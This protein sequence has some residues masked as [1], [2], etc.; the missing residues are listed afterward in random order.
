MADVQTKFKAALDVIQSLPKDGPYRPAPNMLLMFYAYY[1][2]ATEGPCNKPKPWS[3]DVINKAKWDAWNKLGNMT[4]ETA[5]DNYVKELTKVMQ[6]TPR[7]PDDQIIEVLPASDK[8][9]N[10][11]QTLGNFYEVV[12]VKNQDV[13]K[14]KRLA[15]GN[16]G[17][18]ENDETPIPKVNGNHV[19]SNGHNHVEA[20]DDITA[21]DVIVADDRVQQEVEVRS[22]SDDEFCDT[23]TDVAVVTKNYSLSHSEASSL[24]TESLN[25]TPSKDGNVSAVEQ[26]L[27]FDESQPLMD[28]GERGAR[29]VDRL[30]STHTEGTTSTPSESTYP[31]IHDTPSRLPLQGGAGG[32]D[33]PWR[34]HG[35]KHAE[36][37]ERI[38][39]V[40]LQLQRDMHSVLNR[41]TTLE[42][43][44]MARQQ[45]SQ[46]RHHCCLH[47]SNGKTTQPSW[48]PFSDI[49]PKTAL[50]FIIW[51]FLARIIMMFLRR[52]ARRRR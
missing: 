46:H 45:D 24:S 50:F 44:I 4:Q 43:I 9:A 20:D 23:S 1:K 2:Q 49:H 7:I 37:E 52:Y 25:G 21:D 48:W 18:K 12:D 35:D 38:A 8:S 36:I 51:P 22:E 27:R 42:T 47:Q 19:Q 40:L 6:D 14:L 17:D 39:V 31:Q 34:N 5:M 13:E 30:K 16:A 11:I 26:L 41:L 33:E 32:S 28:G 15:A 29:G 10:F 3:F